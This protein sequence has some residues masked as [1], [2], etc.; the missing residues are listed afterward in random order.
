VNWNPY[1]RNCPTRNMLDRIG[2]RWTVLV[3]KLLGRAPHRYTEIAR[4]LDGISQKVLTQTLRGLERD[5]L[6]TRTV[7]AEVP[8]RVDYD[9]TALG[10]TLLDVLD[11]MTGWAEE[12]MTEV[13]D[14]RHAYD[15]ARTPS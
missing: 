7:Q 11:A 2:D 8:L 12:H 14:A 4:A 9:L 1:D 3:V 5:G 10:K 15:S 13:L 6:V